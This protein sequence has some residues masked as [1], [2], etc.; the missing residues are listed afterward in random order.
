M[1]AAYLNEFSRLQDAVPTFST[2]QARVLLEE[3]LGRPVDQ[4][5]GGG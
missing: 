4:V 3:G 5:G 1:P 2:A